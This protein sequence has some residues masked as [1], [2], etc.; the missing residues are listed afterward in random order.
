[1]SKLKIVFLGTPELACPFLSRIVADGYRVS[2][3]ISQPDRLQ[4]R[5]MKLCC[6][7]VKNKAGQLSLEVFQPRTAEDL[8]FALSEFKPDLGVA[9][10]YGRLIKKEAL[11]IPRLGFLNVHFSLLPKY[12]GAAPVQRALMNGESM[13]GVTVFWLD[14]GLDTGPVY[15]S[16]PVPVSP[17]DYAPELFQKTAEAGME[18]LSECLAGIAAG[19][20]VKTPQSGGATLAPRISPADTRLDFSDPAA[21]VRDLVRGLAAG[22]RARFMIPV[23]SRPAEVQ[24]V[25]CSLPSGRP[26]SAAR[27]GTITGIERTKGFYIQ[28]SDGELLMEEVQPEGKKPMK[29]LDFLNGSRLKPGDTVIGGNHQLL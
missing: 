2:G 20:I 14:E 6:P 25:R 29:A 1:M 5:G 9:V 16:R 24:V 27:P 8:I 28:C 17:E 15:A 23:G 22:P 26:G 4:G 21:S 19:R 7:P 12:R 13:T 18:L 11:A 10:A 3:V